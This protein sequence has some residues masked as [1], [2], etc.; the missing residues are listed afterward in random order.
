MVADSQVVRDAGNMWHVL[1]YSAGFAAGTV[2]GMTIEEHIALRCTSVRVICQVQLAGGEGTAD[3]V[4]SAPIVGVALE[5]AK[6]D[7]VWVLVYPH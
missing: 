4:E 5:E 7:K 2:V 6:D 1:G 3:M